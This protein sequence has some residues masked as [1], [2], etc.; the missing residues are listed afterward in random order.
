MCSSGCQHVCLVSLATSFCT[1]TSCRRSHDL[2][3]CGASA[4]VW[5]DCRSCPPRIRCSWSPKTATRSW[6]WFRSVAWCCLSTARFSA[7]LLSATFPDCLSTTWRLSSRRCC[8]R[9]PSE[10]IWG[11]GTGPSVEASTTGTRSGWSS[12]TWFSLPEPWCTSRVPRGNFHVCRSS[13][14]I[15]RRRLQKAIYYKKRLR[16]NRT[17]VNKLVRL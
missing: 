6:R 16:R 7:P 14:N 8:L 15:D 11:C 9:A 13:K 12:T 3:C 17:D 1:H 4:S 5:S 2:V 10:S